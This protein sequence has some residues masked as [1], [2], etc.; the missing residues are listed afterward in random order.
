[1]ARAL[2]PAV[3]RLGLALSDDHALGF[4]DAVL[5]AVNAERRIVAARDSG[6]S[7]SKPR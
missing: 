6:R 5:L 3:R 7:A 1:M 4:T 2:G